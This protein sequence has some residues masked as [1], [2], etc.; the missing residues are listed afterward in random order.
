MHDFMIK[1]GV[2]LSA[3]TK[4]IAQKELRE[5]EENV[6]N[7]TEELKKLVEGDKTF[8]FPED[9]YIY[10]IFLKPCKYYPESAFNLASI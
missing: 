10:Q 9:T 2:E 8:R 5:N 7:A 3:E 4:T 6:N 1:A